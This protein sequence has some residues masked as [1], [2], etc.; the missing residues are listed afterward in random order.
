MK[1]NTGFAM[2]PNSFGPIPEPRS[3][4]PEMISTGT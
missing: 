2:N 3:A 4:S 1:L